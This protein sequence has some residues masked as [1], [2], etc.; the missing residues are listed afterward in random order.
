LSKISRGF[1]IRISPVRFSNNF[2]IV[3]HEY[4]GSIIPLCTNN[5]ITSGIAS[6][7]SGIANTIICDIF[8]C[9]FLIRYINISNKNTGTTIYDKA[10]VYRVSPNNAPAIKYINKDFFFT[11]F[12][13]AYIE[14]ANS[15]DNKY[16]SNPH[17]DFIICQGAS[18]TI[19]I[20]SKDVFFPVNSRANL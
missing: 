7:A 15:G 3:I 4:I 18:V 12:T 10:Y 16:D 20:K 13:K 14:N 11:A 9:L 17:L 8:I 6:I 1:N 5:N 2:G 19:S